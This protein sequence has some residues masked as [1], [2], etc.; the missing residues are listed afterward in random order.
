L[1]VIGRFVD[2]CYGHRGL[3]SKFLRQGCAPSNRSSLVGYRFKHGFVEGFCQFSD[4]P[5]GE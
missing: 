3:Y 2:D 1:S 4:C 5:G